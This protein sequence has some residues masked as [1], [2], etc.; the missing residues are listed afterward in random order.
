VESVVP[1]SPE[2]KKPNEPILEIQAPSV[3]E[4]IEV[5]HREK[6][7]EPILEIQAPS[8]SKGI[9]VLHHEKPNEAI[10]RQ[11]DASSAQKLAA[12]SPNPDTGYF[13]HSPPCHSVSP[14]RHANRG[15]T[16]LSHLS[17]EQ[18]QRLAMELG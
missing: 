8:V 15:A 14:Q 10:L 13:Y 16:S 11:P 1:I 2:A 18:L 9:E 7:N 17:D 3:S 6:P 5:L 4:G 12:G